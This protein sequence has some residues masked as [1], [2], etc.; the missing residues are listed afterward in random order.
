MHQWGSISVYFHP[1]F[2]CVLTPPL[3]SRL[4]ISTS[5]STLGFLR[6]RFYFYQ[7]ISQHLFHFEHLF[8]EERKKCGYWK[9][10][11]NVR[12][13][14]RVKN[15]KADVFLFTFYSLRSILFLLTDAFVFASFSYCFFM[16][17]C[18]VFFW[19]PHCWALFQ[20]LF[21]L[22]SLFRHYK[23]NVFPFARSHFCLVHS[24]AR[25]H[26]RPLAPFQFLLVWFSRHNGDRSVWQ[27]PNEI[28]NI[29]NNGAHHSSLENG[30]SFH[31]VT[32]ADKKKSN[33][34]KFFQV[35]HF[36]WLP[37]RKNSYR[38]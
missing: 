20:F 31:A 6:L 7:L 4:P 33:I 10:R 14:S 9:K 27:K 28:A 5:T 17:V 24:L 2:F 36:S 30:P 37:F 15:G 38:L 13:K 22:G 16:C 19:L 29:F 8:R 25:S 1:N 35:N 34:V 12:K 3:S 23:F 32:E 21:T 26:T 18:F 11:K